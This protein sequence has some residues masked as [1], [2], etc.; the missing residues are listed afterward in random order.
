[1]TGTATR[2]AAATASLLLAAC[3]G[4][5]G[6]SGG[7]AAD[8]RYEPLRG[9][10]AG[11]D[12]ALGGV[13][14]RWDGPGDVVSLA[15][16]DGF[17]ISRVTGMLERSTGR[18]ALT[19]SA[20]DES[21]E[22]VDGDGFD[23]VDVLRDD[24]S[25][26]GSDDGSDGGSDDGANGG[27]GGGAVVSRPDVEFTPRTYQYVMPYRWEYSFGSVPVRSARVA[28]GVFGVVTMDDDV[29]SGEGS[30]TAYYSGT[31]AGRAVVVSSVGGGSVETAYNLNT[32]TSLIIADFESGT[33]SATLG[34]FEVENAESRLPAQ[35]V[36]FGA[37]TAEMTIDGNRFSGTDVVV[38]NGALLGGDRQ[39]GAEGA[40][41]GFDMADSHP[42]EVGGVAVVRGTAGHVGVVFLA[43]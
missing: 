38:E 36:S 24:G 26:G 10:T 33:V 1:M 29:P 39:G 32:G 11:T 13:A 4:G 7:A 27:S 31:A 23:A 12:S 42:D 35:G 20:G 18:V 6:G 43:D 34:N 40:F 30:G 16:V 22:L 41:F 3:G 17:S 25:D 28:R 19:M 14:V 15:S 9:S 2:I 37:I 21:S 8:N 5:G